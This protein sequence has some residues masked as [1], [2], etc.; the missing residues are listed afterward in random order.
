MNETNLITVE[1]K[2]KSIVENGLGD[3]KYLFMNWSQANVELDKIEGPSIIYILP[4]SGS[5]DFKNNRAKDYPECQIAFVCS[6]EFDFEGAE[7]DC[8]IEEM[9]NLLV[10]F[11]IKANESELFETIEGNVSYKVLYDYT[12]DNVTGIVA[13]IPLKEVDGIKTCNI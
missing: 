2:V 13:D 12:D 11:V 1:S 9:K 5:I 4:A 7:N 10:K 3:V 8:I 6:T